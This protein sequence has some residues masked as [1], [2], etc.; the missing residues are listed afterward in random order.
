LPELVWLLSNGE[1]DVEG[2]RCGRR[3]VMTNGRLVVY[4][5]P[6]TGRIELLMLPARALIGRLK[7][8]RKFEVCHTSR[9]SLE[10]ARRR[11]HVAF[12]GEIHFFTSPLRL[13][14]WRGALRTIVARPEAS[15]Q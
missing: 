14:L 9:G 5:A 13:G 8:H 11:V 3:R 10:L 4:I 2:I 12:D 7:E 15:E 6:E 1:Y